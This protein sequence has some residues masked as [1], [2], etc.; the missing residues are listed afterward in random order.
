MVSAHARSEK[1]SAEVAQRRAADRWFLERGL[2][3]VL[4]P[5]ALVRRLWPRSA[6]ALAVFAV[7]MANS[8]L[9]V[10]ISGKHTIDIDGQPTRTEWFVLGLLVLVLPVAATVGWR[11]SRIRSVRIRTLVA[12]VS[13]GVVVAGGI[14]GG[15]SPRILTNLVVEGIVI[16]I[17][18]ALTACGAGSILGWGLR[19]AMDNLASIGALFVRALPVVLLTVLVFFNSYVWLMA[20]I[21]SRPRLWLALLF[22][23]LIAV[24]FITSATVDRVRPMLSGSRHSADDDGRLAGTPFETMPDPASGEPL[25]QPERVNVVFVLATSQVLQVGLVAIVAALIF[26]VLGLILLS[27][28][29]LAQWTRNGSTDGQFLGMTLP[30]PQSLIQ[31]SMFLAALTFMYT[32]ARAVGDVDYRSQFLDPLIDDLR[33]TLVARS[34]YR[35]AVSPRTSS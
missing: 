12:F 28:E 7:F 5:G 32:S 22:L 31:T 6:P 23:G 34:R 35:A 21:V 2:P 4:R 29:L 17:V 1:A 16:V 25:S 20:S 27:P 9:V 3:A 8:I 10:L 13:V 30:V 18:L 24:A 14:L 15:P 11:V 19:T 33:L 26:F